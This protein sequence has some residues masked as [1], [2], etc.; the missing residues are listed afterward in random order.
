MCPISMNGGNLLRTVVKLI[1]YHVFRFFT[2][3]LLKKIINVK[4]ISDLLQF[5]YK[6]HLVKKRPWEL[7]QLNYMYCVAVYMLLSSRC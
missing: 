7:R 4:I 2:N 5:P 1:F 6:C 3:S